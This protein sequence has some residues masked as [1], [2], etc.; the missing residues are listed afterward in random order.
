MTE[1][2][3]DLA[4]A[5]HRRVDEIAERG[6]DALGELAELLYYAEEKDS[7]QV[8]RRFVFLAET[9]KQMLLVMA[10][11]MENLRRHAASELVSD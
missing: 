1:D 8:L 4:L 2:A 6:R 10:E 7:L 9:E 11:R 5:I 3:R